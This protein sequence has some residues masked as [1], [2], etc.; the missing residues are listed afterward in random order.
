MLKKLDDFSIYSCC[1]DLSPPICR[2]NQF[3]CLIPI[4][5]TRSGDLEPE[6]YGDRVADDHLKP[7]R[8]VRQ[9]GRRKT[10][11]PDASW[12]RIQSVRLVT[13]RTVNAAKTISVRQRTARKRSEILI[14][15]QK[16]RY[17]THSSQ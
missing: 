4:C 15:D 14:E 12:S 9:P 11:N 7:V 3:A 1:H 6:S 2:R 10:D 5:S 16:T 17:D 8:F 13:R